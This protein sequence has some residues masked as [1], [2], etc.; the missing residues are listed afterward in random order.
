VEEQTYL[1]KASGKLCRPFQR[2]AGISCRAYSTRLQRAITDFGADISFARVSEKIQEHYGIRI[3]SGA[4]AT[5]TERHASRMTEADMTP[6]RRPA[7]GAMTLIAQSDGSM[8]PVVQTGTTDSE[9]PKDRRKTR[10]VFWKEAKLSMIRRSDE[11]KP[12]FA[13]TLG[14]AVAA[15]ADLM[16]LAVAAGFDQRSRVHGL[17][18]GQSGSR[19]R[20]SGN[21]VRKAP[22]SWT[23]TTCAITSPPPRFVPQMIRAGWSNRK[24]A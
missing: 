5:I 4:A 19:I 9:G 3:A 14:D 6:E 22:T 17:G 13:V 21:S 24:I 11:I 1:S 10:K 8:V 12:A 15:G 23:F 18:M 7:Q 16:R 2:A 20:W